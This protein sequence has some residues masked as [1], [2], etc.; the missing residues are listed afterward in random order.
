[1]SKFTVNDKCSI[2]GREWE[3]GARFAGHH[4][5]WIP[6]EIERT[7]CFNCHQW[8]HGRRTF[9]YS[10]KPRLPKEPTLEDKQAVAMAPY[11]FAKMVVAM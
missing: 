1:M 3:K 4:I 7:L 11:E 5:Q 8:V 10:M 6:V 2:C 9:P